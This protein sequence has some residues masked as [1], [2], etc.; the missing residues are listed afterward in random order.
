MSLKI[1]EC[2]VT[3]AWNVTSR[4]NLLF[5]AFYNPSMTPRKFTHNIKTLLFCPAYGRDLITLL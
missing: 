3:I 2:A 4:E 1:D 5:A